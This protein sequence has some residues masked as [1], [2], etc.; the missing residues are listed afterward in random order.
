M[1][2]RLQEAPDVVEPPVAGNGLPDL[3]AVGP[4]DRAILYLFIIE[5][6]PHVEVAEIVGLSEDATRARY[7]RALK[8]LRVE[9]QEEATRG[10]R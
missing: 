10:D 4:T 6:R 2:E 3:L 8:R 9:T 7:S 1:L 5:G